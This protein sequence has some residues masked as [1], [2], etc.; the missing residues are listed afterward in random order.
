MAW[1]SKSELGTVTDFER[2]L[3]VVL[4]RVNEI[5]HCHL[6]PRRRQ[7]QQIDLINKACRF[8]SVS[9]VLLP[10]TDPPDPPAG[11]NRFSEEQEPSP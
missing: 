11:G 4:D 2:K 8:R 6:I 7:Q 5:G 3:F 9:M 1:V 10:L